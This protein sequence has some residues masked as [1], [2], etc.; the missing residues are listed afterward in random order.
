MR[1]KVR[2]D[3]NPNTGERIFRL[4]SEGYR[5][6]PLTER[7]ARIMHD[8]LGLALGYPGEFVLKQEE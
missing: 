4:I 2:T 1:L 8:L 3:I 5:C 7:E 6:L